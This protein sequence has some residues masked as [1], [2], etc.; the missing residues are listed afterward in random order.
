MLKCHVRNRNVAEKA[1]AVIETG[2]STA[3]QM[4][5]LQETGEQRLSDVAPAFAQVGVAAQR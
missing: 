4:Q 5:K 3:D 1:D 2:S